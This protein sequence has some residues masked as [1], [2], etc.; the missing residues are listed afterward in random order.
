M[1]KKVA[2]PIVS[3]SIVLT[4]IISLFSSVFAAT[5]TVL[6]KTDLNYNLNS[7]SFNVNNYRHSS[8]IDFK[9]SDTGL[10]GRS[11]QLYFA[12]PADEYAVTVQAALGKDWGSTSGTEGGYGIF[13]ETALSADNK[14]T[15]YVVQFDRAAGG[16]RIFQHALGAENYSTYKS[17]NHA[18]EPLIPTD[19]TDP[20][21]TQVH[22]LTVEVT[23]VPST[24]D[25]KQM[26]LFID[27]QK[28]NFTYK[29][30]SSVSAAD[31]FTG[32]RSWSAFTTFNSLTTTAY[33][34]K[35]AD[36][37]APVVMANADRAANEYG[38]YNQ[39]VLVSFSA[40]DEAGGSG[41][42]S[43][44]APVTVSSEGF[45]QK[46][47]GSAR[48]L[49]GNVGTASLA[50]NIDKTAPQI[51]WGTSLQ[52]AQSTSSLPQYLLNAPASLTWQAQDLGASG[53]ATANLGS[54]VLDTSSTG[55]KSIVVEAIDKAGNLTTR[56]YDY[57]VVYAFSG[58]LQPIN[59]D[60]SSI[61]KAGS[62]VPV[63]FKL[64]DYANLTVAN[65][66]ATLSVTKRSDAVNG[67]VLETEQLLN[68]SSG[69][70]FK[71]DATSGQYQY[72]L[73]TKG[74]TAGT[75]MIKISLNDV[76]SYTVQISLR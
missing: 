12:N 7:A 36:S 13:F 34:Y 73:S 6:V 4:V 53:L 32:L 50:L 16:I 61:F 42:D 70:L 69:N 22:T 57:Q 23:R 18:T 56:M 2:R 11:G 46:V 55:K 21:W 14:D 64:A 37:T 33:S 68:A 26:N 38:W 67:S 66:T 27:G 25:Q 3:L 20:W 75:Y 54:S 40:V 9:P 63:K 48:D 47:S 51:D 28:L 19:K 74:W 60:N 52:V 76:Q 30:T 10:V 58:I 8:S 5:G 35:L 29:F 15:G 24:A 65:V 45:G 59:A 49:A 72:N 41:I 31:N 17:Y 1:F 39:D 62:T 43:V 44:D 71:Y